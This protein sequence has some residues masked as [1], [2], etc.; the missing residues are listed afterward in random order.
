MASTW[1]PGAVA[2][3]IVALYCLVAIQLTSWFMKRLPRKLWHAVHMLSVPL[4]VTGTA[5]G[6]LAGADWKNRLVQWG[7]VLVSVNVVWLATFRVLVSKTDPAV[8]D[9]LAAARAASA[10]AKAA[11]A[12]A[13]SDTALADRAG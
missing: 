7:L 8:N 3:G 5:H 10:A 11:A 1:R 9:R 6:I 13:S 2:W 4:F 12:G